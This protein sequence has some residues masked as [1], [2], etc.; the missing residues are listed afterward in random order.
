MTEAIPT[1]WPRSWVGV[2]SKMIWAPALMARVTKNSTDHSRSHYVLHLIDWNIGDTQKIELNCRT[3]N[4]SIV[5]RSIVA[6]SNCCTLNCRNTQKYNGRLGFIYLPGK[7]TQAIMNTPDRKR[8]IEAVSVRPRLPTHQIAA[9][10]AGSSKKADNEKVTYIE[11]GKFS[12]FRT[13]ASNKT[14][15]VVLNAKIAWQEK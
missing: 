14:Q 6:H 15:I 7:A 13:W 1:P 9:K 10:S 12:M 4:C 2:T 3:L 11:Y 8:D 5:A